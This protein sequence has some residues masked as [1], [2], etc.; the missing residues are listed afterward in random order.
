MLVLAF[1][2]EF[3]LESLSADTTG[4]QDAWSAEGVCVGCGN[5]PCVGEVTCG[6]S[7]DTVRASQAGGQPMLGAH[8]CHNG[9]NK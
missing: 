8:C 2:I 9:F 1:V 7:L 3:L 6:D 4:R 5:S